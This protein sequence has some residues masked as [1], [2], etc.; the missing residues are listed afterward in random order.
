MNTANPFPDRLPLIIGH[1]GA[2][3]SAPEN[4]LAAFEQ[5]MRDGADGVEFDVRLARDGV[6]VVIHDATLRRTARRD[7][8]VASLSSSELQEADAGTW[9]NLKFPAQ[10]REHFSKERVPTL[11]QVLFLVGERAQSLYVEMKFEEGGNFRPLAAAV[12]R[13]IR[14]HGL[15]ERAIVESFMLDAIVEVK[16][17]AP[18]IRT[19]ALFDRSLARPFISS[20]RIIELALR[21]QADEIALHRSLAR[22]ALVAQA[23]R[24]GLRA[25]VWTADN[26][27]WARRALSYGLS[28][29]ITN[30]PALLRAALAQVRGSA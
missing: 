16:R 15:G 8:T 7:A 21:T 20:R 28:A 2:S 26:P 9:F 12:V 13:E 30:Q 22:R 19:A 14:E 4:T 25:L 3:R 11:A 17:I 5:A 27:V 24:S 29:I 18:E 6:P 10:A 1:R 23:R